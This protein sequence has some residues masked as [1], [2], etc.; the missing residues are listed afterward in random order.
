MASEIARKEGI[1][2]I[3]LSAN[4]GARIGFA[5]EVKEKFHVAWNNPQDHSKGI[6]YLYLEDA[7]YKTLSASTSV[8]CVQQDGLWVITD[9]IGAQHGIG[10]ENLSGSGLIAAE[11]SLAYEETFTISMASGRSVGIGAYL[12][13]L[14]QRLVQTDAPII[15]TGAPALNKV[16][17][18]E[19][20]ESNLQIGG[21]QIMYP[22]GVTHIAV[23]EDLA[24][25]AVIVRWLGYVPKKRGSALPELQ[26]RS[27]FVDSP[28]RTIDFDVATA[29]YDVRHMLAGYPNERGR[30][31]SG[32]FD[33]GSFMETLGGWGQTVI[34][35]R[36]RLGGL[37]VGVLAV[38]TRAVERVVPADPADL[39]SQVEVTAQAA[40]VWF[41]DSAYKT[42]QAI[43]DFNYGEQLPLFFFANLRG[44]SGGMRDM[45]FEILKYGS[46]IVDNLRR[47]RQPI[48]VYIPP[49]G[50]LRGG[51]WV[52]LDSLINPDM[53]EM[54]ADELARGGVLEPSGIVEIKYRDRDLIKTMHRIDD[55]IRALDAQLRATTSADAEA[56]QRLKA[57]IAA[58]EKELLPFYQQMSLKFADLHDTPGRMK[59]KGVI[60]DIVKW[61]DA[62]RF[63]SR[64]LRRRV[65]EERLCAKMMRVSPGL[66]R[67]DAFATMRV[68]MTAADPDLNYDEDDAAIA[69]LLANEDIRVMIKKHLKELRTRWIM[70]RVEELAAE[71]LEAVRAAV[72]D[73][74]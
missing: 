11:T 27:T 6:K 72:S 42:A 29:K 16:L 58:R 62:R 65:A 64:R 26:V 46:Y 74:L 35:G 48:F 69:A 9:I 20:Y 30:Y 32:F 5:E 7:D 70:K 37:P 13:R 71:D 8:K 60:R 61:P 2:R 55:K 12:I 33:K 40:H 3:Y 51:A 22:N 47:Y 53:M 50:E 66:A 24:G 15:L 34:C 31:V 10:V 54:Y 45:F 1:P 36:A 28:D 38:D 14:G 57:Q 18:K 67:K 17:G 68:W 43:Q 44:F 63:F 23:A 49:L 52:V 59:L 4:S 39:T 25:V 19:V 73:L 21:Q 41:P 56:V